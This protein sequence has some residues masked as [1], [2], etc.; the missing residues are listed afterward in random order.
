VL[1]FLPAAAPTFPIPPPAGRLLIPAVPAA[2]PRR[3]RRSATAPSSSVR[4]SASACSIWQTT[5]WLR[6]NCLSSWALGAS[7][8][9]APHPA[10]NIP[11]EWPPPMP[12]TPNRAP[13][14]NPVAVAHSHVHAGCNFPGHARRVGRR[15]RQD[16]QPH[17][18]A[19]SQP[20]HFHGRSHSTA[21]QTP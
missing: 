9:P 3:G 7:R 16:P 19:P 11:L 14:T 10:N 4:I 20:I 1:P 2:P 8:Q 17:D 13:N 5:T 15:P 18:P 12:E 6:P 21:R